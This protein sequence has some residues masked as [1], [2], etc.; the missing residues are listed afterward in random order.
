MCFI[1]NVLPMRV[2]SSFSKY[3]QAPAMQGY[4]YRP[5]RNPIYLNPIKLQVDNLFERGVKNSR[6]RMYSINNEL[7]S[8]LQE[9]PI[10]TDKVNTYAYD[11]TRNGGKGKYV[12]FLH[13]LGQNISALQEM[14]NS[15]LNNTEYSIF[16]P[17]YRCFGKNEPA[18]ISTKTFLEDSQA[19]LDYM[20]KEKQIPPDDICVIG[21]SFGGFVAS[22]LVKKNQDVDKLI[23]VSS[24]DNLGNEILRSSVMKHIS[25]FALTILKHIKFL[26]TYLK[27]LFST[28]EQLE[29]T[30]VPVHIIHSMNDRVVNYSSAQYLAENCQNLQSMNLLSTGGHSME[31]KKIEAIISLLK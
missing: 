27:N 10:K 11:I 26:R 22:Q 8:Y 15:I 28:K 18:T 20:V 13:G 31:H 19:A 21:H 30:A 2:V 24:V 23:L 1:Y 5:N 9:V 3:N 4:Q 6:R 29:S 16:V 12:L 17:E 25:P 14:Y 7:S